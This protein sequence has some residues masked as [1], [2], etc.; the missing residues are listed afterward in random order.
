MLSRF[1][2]G[3]F[4]LNLL[5][6]FFLINF[7][8]PIH[9]SCLGQS[10][11]QKME[12]PYSKPSDKV[13]FRTGFSFL[14][15]EQHEQSSWVAYELTKNEV[16][17]KFSERSNKFLP[18]PLVLTGTATSKD[19]LYAGY[20]RGHLAPAADMG[21]SEEAMAESF[22]YSNICPQ[23]PSF[24]RG[25][26][27]LLEELIRG[28]AV[29]KETLYVVTGPVL[30]A[31]L[32]ALRNSHISIPEYFYK[33]IL[34]NTL[35]SIG[36]IGFLIPSNAMRDPIVTYA[37]SIDSVEKVTGLDFYFQLPDSMQKKLESEVCISC[38]SWNLARAE[39]S[40][41]NTSIRLSKNLV[42]CSGITKSGK[43]CTRN[44]FCPNG[45]CFQH[46]CK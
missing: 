37:V 32:K 12:L 39:N 11:S 31:G 1:F 18:D 29:E 15:N 2:T 33:V 16:I 7:H 6:T 10:S 45:R 46:G 8:V 22:F 41:I 3:S 34:D 43:R 5:R 27:K 25:S 9:S 42:R 19:Y 24:N 30:K 13:I 14:Y 28:W 36:G 21:W 26:W 20:D 4:T 35:P 40:I 17:N 23:L 38:W 44:T